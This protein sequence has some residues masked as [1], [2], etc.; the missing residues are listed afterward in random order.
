M[1][2]KILYY[3][4]TYN[5]NYDKIKTALENN[6]DYHDVIYNGNYITIYDENYPKKLLRLIN[7]PFILF[8]KGDISALNKPSVSIVGSRTNSLYSDE[9]CKKLIDR[10]DNEFVTISGLAKG[11]DASVHKYSHI[12]HK[13][14]GVL[15]CGID[16]VYP[17]C[18]KNIYDIMY[19]EHLV[20]SEYPGLCKPLADNFRFRNRIISGLS[21]YL[22]VIEAGLKSGTLISVNYALE[23]GNDIYCVPHR[24]SDNVSGCNY[25]I[26]EGAN[27]LYDI[28]I[29]SELIKK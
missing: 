9:I 26:N 25:L 12:N 5:G 6:E 16:Y 3:A 15:G 1:R 11:V 22:F 2:K 29:V 27:I 14:I 19:K 17:Y 13:S 18:N 23:V 28:N 20:I 4:L 8:Y 7:P 24:L 10:L 21:N